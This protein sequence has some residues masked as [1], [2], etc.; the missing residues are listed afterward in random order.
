MTKYK[1]IAR[2][3]DKKAVYFWESREDGI[4]ALVNSFTLKTACGVR[5]RLDAIK[6]TESL[7]SN[8]Y[9]VA[10]FAEVNEL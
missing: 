9:H 8:G 5:S 3:L 7:K 4:Y 2:L 6:L 10:K 1:T